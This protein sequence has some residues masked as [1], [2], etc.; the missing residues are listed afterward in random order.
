MTY[1][2]LST[3]INLLAQFVLHPHLKRVNMI[4]RLFQFQFQNRSTFQFQLKHT[5]AI[6][7]GK[8]WIA[9]LSLVWLAIFFMTDEA[10]STI[11]AHAWITFSLVSFAMSGTLCGRSIA[12]AAQV[13]HASQ[14]PHQLWRTWLNANARHGS[15]MLILIA[16]G[17]FLL[18]YQLS[19]SWSWSVI[20]AMCSLTLFFSVALSLSYSRLINPAYVLLGLTCLI[21]L[22][23]S[24]STRTWSDLQ[25]WST[26]VKAWHALFILSWPILMAMMRLQWRA[27]PTPQ[28]ALS[29]FNIG[30]LTALFQHG[31]T[32]LQRFSLL[33]IE[34][35]RSQAQ[36]SAFKGVLGM[37]A[38]IICGGL[39]LTSIVIPWGA[40]VTIIHL[41]MLILFIN[42]ASTIVVCKD[43]HWR[44]LLLPK[45]YKE[46]HIGN[47]L[48]IST[49]IYYAHFILVATTTIALLMFLFF[50]Q[51]FHALKLDPYGVLVFVLEIVCGFCIGIAIRG[52]AKPQR[53]IFYGFLFFL[54]VFAI[55]AMSIYMS[56]RSL[57]TAGLFEIGIPYVLFL[58]GLSITGLALAN[59]LWTVGRLRPFISAIR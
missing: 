14:I 8:F 1:L 40:N 25:A 22:F 18:S 29:G 12:Q 20:L 17:G 51:R 4:S 47:H 26:E 39:F 55:L 9:T 46:G 23:A 45:K 32:Y 28:T 13:F 24:T 31:R 36:A 33:N 27:P 6:Y 10:S 16:I 49:L 41:L 58:L 44:Y 21:L 19:H 5:L 37:Q 52:S 56:G 38:L 3:Q 34:S 48:L 11:Y 30:F 53:T 7:I 2:S 43:L 50:P 57:M 42:Y 35:I 15:Q 59:R 54:L